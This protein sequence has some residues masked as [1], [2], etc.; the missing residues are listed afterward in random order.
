MKTVITFWGIM[1]ICSVAWA[2]QLVSGRITDA[3]DGAPVAGVEVFI[4]GT[5]TGTRTSA[6]GEY[7]LTVP[8][9]GSF[10][11][12]VSHLDYQSVFHKIDTPQPSHRYDVALEINEIEAVTVTA[13]RTYRQSDVNLFWSRILGERPSRNGM[14]VL[15]PEKVYFYLNRESNVLRA[16]CR[17]PVEIVNHKTGYHI[18]YVLESFRHDYSSNETEFYG[19]PYFEELVPQNSRQKNNWEKERQKVYSVSLNRFLRALY[20]EQLL[21][22]GFVLTGKEMRIIT[23]TTYISLTNFLVTTRKIRVITEASSMIG[24][25]NN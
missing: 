20:W 2:Q 23:D 22:E 15:N 21:E 13:D 14:Q 10:E 24:I 5:T 7:S 25:Y 8:G 1:L 16:Y 19:Q 4:A 11:I 6:E 17:E 18:R 12:V 9:N 3:A